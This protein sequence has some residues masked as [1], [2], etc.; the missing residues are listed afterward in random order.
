M[1]KISSEIGAQSHK[2]SDACCIESH[3][4]R[5]I[6]QIALAAYIHIEPLLLLCAICIVE[7]ERER[8]MC[9]KVECAAMPLSLH[10][11]P[12]R[13]FRV[14]RSPAIFLSARVYA[15]TRRVSIQHT[16]THRRRN[17]GIG[18]ISLL[19]G[20]VGLYHLFASRAHLIFL[21]LLFILRRAQSKTRVSRCGGLKV[22]VLDMPL[23]KAYIYIYIST[24]TTEPQP[25]AT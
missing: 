11:A 8:E 7:R 21:H 18:R 4:L 3:V 12:K 20:A 23:G 19:P 9:S 22:R 24:H 2:L 25:H 6:Y 13:A 5:Y 10:R 1:K 15:V 14:R 17:I 16:H